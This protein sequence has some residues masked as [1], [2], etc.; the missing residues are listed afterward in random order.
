MKRYMLWAVLAL[1]AIGLA[2]TARVASAQEA[3]FKMTLTPVSVT[4]V[5]PDEEFIDLTG[6]G[7]HLGLCT[8]V[9]H[10]FLS[11]ARGT[12]TLTAANG[13]LLYLQYTVAL[14]ETG[15]EWIHTPVG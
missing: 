15:T 7:T 5:N 10:D 11:E 1:A 3:A 13:D 9:A 14:N 4:V 2:L 6:N 8:A 12:M